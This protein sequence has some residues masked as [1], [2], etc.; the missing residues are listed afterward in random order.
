MI[1]VS[2]FAFPAEFVDFGRKSIIK[3]LLKV[4]KTHVTKKRIIVQ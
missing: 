4:S 3:I 1:Y 2:L